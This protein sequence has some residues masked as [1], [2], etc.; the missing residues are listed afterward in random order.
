VND[1][2]ASCWTSYIQ[3]VNGEKQPTV[4]QRCVQAG[5]D[6][7]RAAQH[8]AGRG[9]MA[10]TGPPS[11]SP[12]ADSEQRVRESGSRGARFPCGCQGLQRKVQYNKYKKENADPEPRVKARVLA[13]ARG[14]W[15]SSPG[16]RGG[17]LLSAGWGVGGRDPCTVYHAGA[18]CGVF[19]RLSLLMKW[20]QQHHAAP[21][22][23]RI[24]TTAVKHRGEA[25]HWRKTTSD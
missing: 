6:A 2:E 8:R 3:T 18:S 16:A 17:A 15:T 14:R 22:S 1:P 19:W 23:S 13:E 9:S 24:S 4:E 21:D 12:E 11:K 10:P 20:Q 25:Q 5:V 7:P